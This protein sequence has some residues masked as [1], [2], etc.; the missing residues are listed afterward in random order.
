MAIGDKWAGKPD[1]KCDNCDRKIM[2]SFVDGRMSNGQWGVMCPSCRIAEGRMQ[3]GVGLG[4]K[5][6]RSGDNYVRTV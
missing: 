5:Y 6:E 2:H 3:L 1:L 4:Q